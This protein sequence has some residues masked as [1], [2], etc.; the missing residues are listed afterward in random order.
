MLDIIFWILLG[1]ILYTYFGYTF[2]LMLMNLLKKL[3]LIFKKSAIEK[4]YIEEVS[5]LIAAYNEES[6]IEVKMKNTEEIDYPKDKLKIVWVTD[7]SSDNSPEVLKNFANVMVLHQ[8]KREGKTA[9]LNRAMKHI[10]TPFTVFCD[11]NT[12]LHPKAVK[13]LINEFKDPKVGCVAGEKRIQKKSSESAAGS[14]EGA[15]WKYESFIKKLESDFYSVLAAAGELYAIRTSLY[16]NVEN[17]IIIDDFFISM[18]IALKGYRLKYSPK[19]YALE[20]PSVSIREE[21]KR[22]IR[23]ASGGIQT[24]VRIPSLLNI[25]K[26]GFLSFEFF[27]HKFLRWTIVPFAIP[28]LFILNLILCTLG[29]WLNQIYC[30]LFLLQLLFYLL[31]LLGTISENRATRYKFLFLPY[32]LIVMNYAQIAGLFRFLG[33]KHSVVWEKAKRS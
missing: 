3:F 8:D 6:V 31:V 10:N 20:S 17:D 16:R 19:A 27:S 29:D 5:L 18:N 13:Y 11:A 7:G 9:A 30:A 12:M 24:I 33:R 15:Y 25:F 21:L 22:K 23:I 32:Y 28:A 26:Y 14:G 1:I 2:L 4:E